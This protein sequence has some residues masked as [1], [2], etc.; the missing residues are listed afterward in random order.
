MEKPFISIRN[1]TKTFNVSQSSEK[2]S[3]FSMLKERK[4]MVALKNLSLDIE[5][6]SVVGI[7]G[8][9]GSGKTTL[10]RIIAGILEPD[11]GTVSIGGNI[12]PLFQIGAGFHR[13][14]N[15][16]ENIMISAML[17]GLPRHAIKKKIPE[18]LKFAELEEFREMKIK[19]YSA[20]MKARL[21]FSTAILVDPDILLVDEILSVGDI[22]FRKK[23]LAEFLKL[24]NERKVILLTTHNMSAVRDICDCVIVM[25]GG[26][27]IFQGDTSEGI[28]KFVE[29]SRSQK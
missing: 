23:S 16:R 21:A 28:E 19:H 13:D 26:R 27:M 18:I 3:L 8:S 20:G 17:S 29:I 1:V 22:S 6:G 15:A 12:A 25:D 2:R 10:L 14:L 5:G 7:I 11:S 24:R 9:N 4:K